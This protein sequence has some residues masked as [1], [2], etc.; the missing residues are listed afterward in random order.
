MKTL[1]AMQIV[2]LLAKAAA[3]IHHLIQLSGHLIK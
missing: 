2:H 3:E 1:L